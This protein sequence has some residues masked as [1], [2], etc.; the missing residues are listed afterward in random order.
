MMA[1]RS[2]KLKVK[3]HTG[4]GAKKLRQGLLKTH[5]L[6]NEGIKYY[7]DWLLLLR[8]EAVGE[9]TKDEIQSELKK[10]LDDLFQKR[11]STLE[12]EILD[13]MLLVLQRLYQ[14]IVPSSIGEKGSANNTASALFPLTDE[15]SDMWK[16]VAK[17]G[18]PPAWKVKKD[19]GDEDWEAAYQKWK[20]KQEADPIYGIRRDLDRLELLPLFCLFTSTQND[21]KWL[22]EG[23]VR[24]W[25]KDMMTQAIERLLSWESWN[26]RVK[27]EY[28]KLTKDIEELET[29]LQETDEEPWLTRLREFEK[30]RHEEIAKVSFEP[31]D[32]FVI[33]KRE[34][35]GWDRLYNVWKKMSPSLPEKAFKDKVGE[36]QQKLGSAFGGAI[37]FHFLAQKR[38]HFIWC[39]NPERLLYFAKH[40][41]MTRKR[42][43]AKREAT[44]T[45]PDDRRHPAWVR[46]ES[47]DGNNLHKYRF[48]VSEEKGLTV[49]LDKLIMPGESGWQ[50]TKD[51]VL[52]L[53][54]SKQFHDQI[55]LQETE[56][57]KEKQKF[58]YLDQ[59][60]SRYKQQAKVL[61][62]TA[63]GA[64]LQFNRRELEKNGD[65]T[66]FFNM[67][68]SIESMQNVR[69]GR[70]QTP[71]GKT[72]TTVQDD[73]MKVVNY[74]PKELQAWMEESPPTVELGCDALTTGMRVMSVDLGQRMA[75]AVSI[76]EVSDVPPARGKLGYPIEGTDLYAVHARSL[77]IKLPGED[78]SPSIMEVRQQ[79]K[80]ILKM[81][82][83][84]M[85][86]LGN[87]L[88]LSGKRTVE[89]RDRVLSKYFSPELLE[90]QRRAWGV[91]YVEELN[92]VK[93]AIESDLLEWNRTVC[94]AHR[95]LES[96]VSEDV[97]KW[98]Q[99]IG[100]DRQGAY[101]LSMASIEEL[102]D[103]Q[104]FL[105]AWSKRA[106][107][108]EKV[109]RAQKRERFGTDRREHIQH[110]K[111]DRLKKLAHELV[112]TALGYK[113]QSIGNQEKQWIATYPSCQVILFEDLSQYRFK[114]DRPKKENSR[115]MQWA[116]REI[117]RVV[118]MKGEMYGLQVGDVYSAFTSRFHA[119][120]GAPGIRCRSLTKKDIKRLHE[121]PTL[122]NRW[123]GEGFLSEKEV[124]WLRE[125]DLVPDKGG[126]VFV[127]LKA[128]DS[129]E[130]SEIHA[131]LNAAQN[132]QKRFWLQNTEVFR[133]QVEKQQD[134]FMVK[135]TAKKVKA[136]LGKGSF[137]ESEKENEKGV[138]YWEKADRKKVRGSSK[139][140]DAESLADVVHEGAELQGKA[141]TLFRDPSGYF[142]EED[143]WQDQKQYWFKVN[144]RIRK[145][146]ERRIKTSLRRNSYV[147]NSN[148]DAK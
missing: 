59:S 147:Y 82:R 98:R 3:A 107:S 30:E 86:F 126:E 85:R 78:V 62:G 95:T 52:P 75:A 138:Y 6:H 74:K 122:L 61:E 13:E 55:A 108:P 117:P 114:T 80:E 44:L 143:K 42:Q 25:D 97:Q 142:F 139:Q 38:N 129:H 40:N 112:M 130:L 73:F 76:F 58:F 24:T 21:V 14:W 63:Q 131:D 16:G 134:G 89:E 36:A 94:R 103:T 71:I 53:A 133:V 4:A 99:E 20:Q 146:L 68:V 17:S 70:L 1:T 5:Q 43:R 115:L 123:C 46:F 23:T 72:L 109:N 91:R 7:M 125:G 35:R 104:R 141:K 113:Y 79:R 9:R 148:S 118:S 47:Q 144:N 11:G 145:L 140:V 132:L 77:T 50:E 51:V 106:R 64:R 90:K 67:T 49:T 39:N 15:K 34:I 81:L 26:R 128:P 45:F 84:K 88:R 124:P 127:T 56:K 136:Y 135:T 18:R 31:I 54:A 120:T 93:R 101:G 69:N 48:T 83:G 116:H 29:N 41:E 110:L 65:A 22:Q 2:Y 8:Q 105:Q 19:R 137:V 57:K 121:D 119:K 92:K 96:Y 60:V 111:E 100:L 32:P 10:R 102:E 28:E 27:D 33:R 87:V 66:A 37:P 12:K